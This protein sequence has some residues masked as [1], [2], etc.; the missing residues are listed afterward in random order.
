MLCKRN[1]V[2]KAT[3]NRAP[4]NLT[5]KL[6]FKAQGQDGQP[7]CPKAPYPGNERKSW[8]TSAALSELFEVKFSKA[9]GSPNC[10]LIKENYLLKTSLFFLLNTEGKKLFFDLMIQPSYQP[11]CFYQISMP[12]GLRFGYVYNLLWIVSK[13][14]L[15]NFL[16][17]MMF[18]NILSS[19]STFHIQVTIFWPSKIEFAFGVVLSKIWQLHVLRTY[20]EWE[21]YFKSNFS[22]ISPH[23]SSIN[24]QKSI[25]SFTL[26]NLSQTKYL[27]NVDW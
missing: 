8:N 18:Y 19:H 24:I 6:Q 7:S 17:I 12:M 9:K 1:T 22:I 25:V 2:A 11:L 13:I 4:W 3:K 27:G 16:S 5:C 26:C 10:N 14:F 21:N 15:Q 23:L 20:L